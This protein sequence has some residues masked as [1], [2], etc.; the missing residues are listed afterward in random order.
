MGLF[1]RILGRTEKIA[2]NQEINTTGAWANARPANSSENPMLLAAA[3]GLSDIMSQSNV[4]RT[5]TNF[6]TD[7]DIYDKMLELDPELNGAVRAVSL[8]ANNYQVNFK[9]AKNGAIREAI[10][11][12]VEETID[13]DD[14]LINAMRNLMVYGNDMN[15]LVGK[16]GVGITQV[17]S[18]PIS[19]MTVTDGRPS[20]EQTD[21]MN[22]IT[23]ATSYIL[24]E[25]DATEERFKSDEVLHIRIDYRSHWFI[26]TENRETYGVWGASRF[27]SLKQAIR[28][29]YN[30]L[31]NRMALEESMT[32]QFITIN[33]SAIEHI[34]DPDEQKARLTYIMD[35][36]VKTLESLRGDQVPI[37]P[38]Y[39]EIHHTDT[40]N[41]I[42]DNT[43]FLDTVNADIAAV[44]QVPRVAAGQERGSTFAATYNAN[45]WATTAIK[46]LQGILAQSV[47]TMFSKHLE[48]MGIEHLRKD[49][50][51]LE[52][53][54]VEDESPSVRMQRANMGYN[55]GILTLNQSLEVIGEPEI[56]SLGEVRK[57]DEGSAPTGR[58]PRRD[59]QPGQTELD[60]IG[61]EE[62]EENPEVDLESTE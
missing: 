23:E 18:L 51:K 36:V 19:Q 43:A 40:R 5:N 24:R 58:L 49:I 47:I 27:S 61:T 22:P 52:F 9:G 44:L 6:V 34:S 16:T 32:K 31:N 48:L 39:I 4:L 42:P 57:G 26:D 30:T 56:G 2:E 29:K 55:G 20:T 1:D 3:A 8:T 11:M 54:P 10:R 38:D 7:F 33:S 53:S 62:T 12:L 59:S 25:G 28:S 14:I 15:K 21:R 50:P 41:T 13:F 46:R 60:D 45:V 35:E 37:F 17:Q